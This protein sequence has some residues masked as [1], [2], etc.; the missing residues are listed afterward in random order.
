MTHSPPNDPAEAVE[1][2]AATKTR[3]GLESERSW[4]L[5]TEANGFL[6][7]GLDLRFIPGRGPDSAAYGMLP[8]TLFNAMKAKFF[9]YVRARRAA[10]VKRSE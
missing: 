8:P 10:L 6:W 9:A 5:V 2:P 3:L 4:I 1:I 7:P